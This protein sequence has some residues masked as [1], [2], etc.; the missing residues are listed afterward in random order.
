MLHHRFRYIRISFLPELGYPVI[1]YALGD[2]MLLEPLVIGKAA[3]AA[4]H[5][6]FKTFV[7]CEILD[8]HSYASLS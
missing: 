8:V 1:K 4:F 5:H 2:P 3:A 7:R 6:E